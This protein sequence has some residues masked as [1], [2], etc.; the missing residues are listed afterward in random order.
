MPDPIRYGLD[1]PHPLSQARTELVWAGKYDV[2]GRRTAPVRV[3]AHS[4]ESSEGEPCVPDRGS[5][6]ADPTSY[7]DT[8]TDAVPLSTGD[9]AAARSRRR[10][11]PTPARHRTPPTTAKN[12]GTSPNTSQP[13]TI[14]SGGT[15]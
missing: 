10:E 5:G 1:N 2:Y 15:T 6:N 9:A 3:G 14:A 12:A 4:A 7:S 8:S 11:M 13:A